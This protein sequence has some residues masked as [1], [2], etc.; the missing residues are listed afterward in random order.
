VLA[1]Q[2]S[3]VFGVCADVTDAHAVRAALDGAAERFGGIDIVVAAAGVFPPTRALSDLVIDD[4]RRTMAVNVDAVALLLS[5]L[6]PFLVLAPR[7]GRVVLI[8][9][10]NVP[11]PGPAAAPYSASNAALTSA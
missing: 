6:H 2:A 3:D 10:K 9:S 4:W 5:W 1:E 11:A 7:G 8:A